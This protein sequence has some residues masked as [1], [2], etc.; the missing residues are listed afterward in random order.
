MELFG[1][2]P[3]SKS[4]QDLENAPGLASVR[5]SKYAKAETTRFYDVTG[6]SN[7]FA[8]SPEIADW[9]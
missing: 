1:V 8:P 6:V 4:L 3:A 5:V 7:A 2:R 9:N